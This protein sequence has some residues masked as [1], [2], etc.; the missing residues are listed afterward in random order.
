MNSLSQSQKLKKYSNL[1]LNPQTK[2]SKSSQMHPKDESLINKNI[3]SL[4]KDLSID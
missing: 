4:S 2:L 3:E 1:K